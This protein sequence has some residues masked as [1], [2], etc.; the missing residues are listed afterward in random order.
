MTTPDN[1]GKGGRPKGPA[2][3]YSARISLGNGQYDWV[4]R[5]ETRRQRDAAKARR[6]LELIEQ[7]NLPREDGGFN[8]PVRSLTVD[9]YAEVFLAEYER[10]HKTSSYQTM[11]QRLKPFCAE[12]G[13]TPLRD[14]DRLAIKEWA[15]GVTSISHVPSAVTLLNQAVDDDQLEKNPARG[16]GEQYEG[17]SSHRPPTEEEFERLLDACW[18]HGRDYGQRMRNLL[19]FAAFTGMRPGE[20]MELKW[21][22]VDF[23]RNRVRVSRRL[24]RGTVD[25]PKSGK[26]KLIVLTPPAREALQAQPRLGEWVFPSKQSPRL[27]SGSL[28]LDWQKVLAKADL[29]FDFYLATKH[30]CVHYL[31]V[32]LNLSRRA[33]AA[34]M[35]WSMKS[36]DKMLAVYGHGEIGALEEIDDAFDARSNV[37]ELRAVRDAETSEGGGI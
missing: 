3:P 7:G 15:A 10:K 26:A 34:Q 25:V 6:R 16:L 5:F 2:K 12:F 33:I 9:Q 31:Y 37:R 32:K 36:V 29:D 11:V 27:A 14:L 35:G 23:D 1:K 8:R 22:D 13:S 21:S 30:Y 4:G 18:V 24:Y 28:S 20:I 17:R 19:R